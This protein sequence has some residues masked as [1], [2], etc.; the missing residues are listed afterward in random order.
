MCL[1]L[2]KKNVV[3]INIEKFTIILLLYSRP[4]LPWAVF[5]SLRWV[6]FADKVF[7]GCILAHYYESDNLGG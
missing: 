6:D 1:M 7:M 2:K 5:K 4:G 3:I